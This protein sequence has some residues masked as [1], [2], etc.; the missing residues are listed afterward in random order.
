MYQE[1][2][3][4]LQFVD[5]TG[6]PILK[7]APVVGGTRGSFG[8]GRNNNRMRQREV[9]P[10]KKARHTLMS[11]APYDERLRLPGLSVEDEYREMDDPRCFHFFAHFDFR[12]C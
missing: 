4:L 7:M 3:T 5:S 11:D 12:G 6:N 10:T 1:R 9:F 8:A 2:W